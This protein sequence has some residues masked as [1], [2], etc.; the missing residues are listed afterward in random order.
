MTS[1]EVAA[2][3]TT[4][5]GT[6]HGSSGGADQHAVHRAEQSALHRGSDFGRDQYVET[7]DLPC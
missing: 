3:T 4:H 5:R 1:A 2:F 6:D 7:T